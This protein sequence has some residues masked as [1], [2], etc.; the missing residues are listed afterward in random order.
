MQENSTSDAE[1]VELDRISTVSQGQQ[2]VDMQGLLAVNERLKLEL[3]GYKRQYDEAMKYVKQFEDIQSI[4][5]DLRQENGKLVAEK[6]ELVRRLDI[7]LMKIDELS[8]REKAEPVP[9][10][11]AELAHL[12][13]QML[14][15]K[16][17]NDK[18]VQEMNK[19][20]QESSE[21]LK[22]KS[23]QND[24][25][26]ATIQNLVETA[27]A[28]FGIPFTSP[29]ALQSFLLKPAPELSESQ[30]VTV[31]S[32]APEPSHVEEE[33]LIQVKRFKKLAKMQT[34][35]RKRMEHACAAVER[36]SEMKVQEAEKLANEL[37]KKILA[38]QEDVKKKDE[39]HKKDIENKDAMI[40]GLQNDL[41][42]AKREIQNLKIAQ[43]QKQITVAPPPPSPTNA[44]EQ[45]EWK[46][47]AQL[48]SEKL[49]E[50]MSTVSSLR[51]KVTLLTSQVK[52]LESAKEELEKE[53][54][55]STARLS[56]LETLTRDLR[57][58]NEQLQIEKDEMDIKLTF[59]ASRAKAEQMNSSK[60]K[61]T[62]EALTG[63]VTQLKSA[64]SRTENL[65]NQQRK[66]LDR[67]R[68]ER[69][70]TIGIIQKLNSLVQV[71]DQQC[72]DM[73]KEVSDLRRK[74]QRQQS[75]PV[76]KP[77]A[78]VATETKKDEVPANA[79]TNNDFPK[80]LLEKIKQTVTMNDF[81]IAH[82][83][84]QVMSVIASFYSEIEK[85]SVQE[86]KNADIEFNNKLSM[87]NK[88][89]LGLGKVVDRCDLS[90][91]ALEAEPLLSHEIPDTVIRLR[92]ANKELL[93]QA[94]L[95]DDKISALLCKLQVNT[96]P[97][98]ISQVDQM[99]KYISCLQS[100]FKKLASKTNKLERSHAAV[101]EELEA[102]K[103]EQN[104]A[105]ENH[106]HEL[107]LKEAEIA[108]DAK[109]HEE[110]LAKMRAE[111][112][113]LRKTQPD[114]TD[115]DDKDD[116]SKNIEKLVL[117]AQQQKAQIALELEEQKELAE[118][119]KKDLERTTKE[120]T[121]WRKTAKLLKT[122][123]EAREHQIQQL[124]K[125]M[126]EQ[127]K[128]N[129]ERM[130]TDRRDQ[131]TKYEQIISEL[132]TKNA[133]LTQ[134][135]DQSAN[136]LSECECKIKELASVN[137]QLAIEKN[138]AFVKFEAQRD[139][140][141]REKQLIDTKIKAIE[142]SS[143][144]QIQSLT[145]QQNS[146]VERAKHEVFSMV[147]NAFKRFFDPRNQLDDEYV[148]SLLE[149]ASSELDRLLK[150]DTDVRRIIGIT[151]NDSIQD[152]IAKVLMS[153]YHPQT[154]T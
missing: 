71:Y 2:A 54:Q 42:Q 95:Q 6:D 72:L 49:K 8:N 153:A 107:E 120:I 93:E 109:K 58:K 96:I 98:A 112:E 9:M 117:E 136:A 135:L 106:K 1:N 85:A 146:R 26:Q 102:K 79:W 152:A 70:S 104:N 29:T 115:G 148:Q 138:Q 143:Q 47:K 20:I 33:L 149:R 27:Q 122:A 39:L 92:Q 99:V 101:V 60:A 48:Q 86:K 83:I 51:K 24:D 23:R 69:T 34:K 50:A 37:E 53:S 111:M 5:S 14:N 119:A 16:M 123:K 21:L 44:S 77:P 76:F 36:K 59:N 22:E 62:I 35:A 15:E 7:S 38:V 121:Q 80:P 32:E 118:K 55:N 126:A 46:E 41:D 137:S 30:S 31:R 110:E 28:R 116:F 11:T 10:F 129:N 114:Q 82:K 154:N 61:V 43:I 131:Q 65:F 89:L 81:P 124:L 151:A 134:F 127:E 128:K 90:I 94:S 113:Q 103:V 150:Q 125:Q 97:E 108:N 87:I 147:A 40:K 75:K 17:E 25:L 63:E 45:I 4:V 132:K 52:A 88:F 3:D 133:S 57:S 91:A 78:P 12:K 67:Y 68:K 19:A 100:K 66:E 130:V 74:L 139:E 73:S 144:I 64:I 13:Q 56:E 141:K 145:E 105:E 18:R 84:Q 140:I 142:L